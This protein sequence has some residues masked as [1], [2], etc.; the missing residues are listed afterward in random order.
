MSARSNLAQAGGALSHSLGAQLLIAFSVLF[1][2]SCASLRAAD[3]C[4]YNKNALLLLDEQS[5]DQ[6][7]SKGGGGWRKIANIPGCELAAAN[8]IAEYRSAHPAS[9]PTLVWH[10]G[11]MRAAAG[12]YKRAIPL[13]ISAKKVPEQ[14]KAGW[15]IYVDATIAFLEGNKPELFRA[16][17]RLAAI[18]F[19]SETEIQP[20]KGGYIEFPAHNG[21]PAM[22]IRWPPN[23]DVVDGLIACFG[24]PYSEAYGRASCRRKSP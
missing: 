22:K 16:R 24:K 11:Q 18:P 20:L 7:L 23:I 8:L 4:T 19:P 21:Q 5:F 12:E 17:D 13:L 6:N 3:G 15:N 9:S 14:D 2:T 10:E 1:I